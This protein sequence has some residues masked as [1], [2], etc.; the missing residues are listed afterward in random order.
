[1]RGKEDPFLKIGE[2]NDR[3]IKGGSD[4]VWSLKDIN[5]EIEQGDAVGII[6]RNGAG[7][8]TLLKI[9]SRVTSPTTGSVK[10]KGRIASL[11]EVGTGFHPELTGRENIYLNG[12]ILG[13]RKAEIK[14]RFDEIVD[15]AGVER[16]IDTPVK[17]YSSGMYV[18]LAFGVAAHLESE[19][20]VVDEVLA[21]GDAE[22][23]K[24]CLG[25]M[26][27]VSK[28]EGRTILFV[29][30]NMESILKLCKQGIYLEKG[31]LFSQS[32]AEKVVFEYISESDLPSTNQHT[33][34]LNK[35]VKLLKYALT[36]TN[37]RMSENIEF[38]I[39]LLS[40]SI[41]K[42]SGLCILIYN[43]YET[44][45]AIID[46]RCEEL[47]EISKKKGHLYLE[48]VMKNI[49]LIPGS[50]TMGLYLNSELCSGDYLN[51]LK[52]QIS[53]DLQ[54]S[55]FIQYPPEVR[56]VAFFNHTLTIK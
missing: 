17:R 24:K 46:L 6:G 3:T 33:E 54:Q 7:K 42:L 50:Y 12:A 5:F 45:V 13:M 49:N 55:A 21:V 2:V 47:V 27:D 23:Q 43:I 34:D 39:E 25:K 18:R 41:N 8:S 32:A 30:H 19:I 44:R 29:S 10:V 4:V 53:E 1:M 9:L 26:S 22:F 37:Y 15:F 28:G 48:G 35:H 20:L 16:Y 31:K 51:I 11:L 56:G 14:R 36:K 40:S 52:I 38:C